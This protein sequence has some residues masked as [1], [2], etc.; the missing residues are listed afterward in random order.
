MSRGM[1]GSS[2]RS[3]SIEQEG[4]VTHPSARLAGSPLLLVDAVEDDGDQRR[5]RIPGAPRSRRL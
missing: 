5:L 2:G 4:G 3:A 1:F